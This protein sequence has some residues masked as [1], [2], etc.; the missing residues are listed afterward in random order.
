MQAISRPVNVTALA[1]C[2]AI[3]DQQVLAAVDSGDDD[4]RRIASGVARNRAFSDQ[5]L[6]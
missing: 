1:M 2:A 3:P 5:I 4:M 6:S